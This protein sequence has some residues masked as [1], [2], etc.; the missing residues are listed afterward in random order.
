LLLVREM[1]TNT[2]ICFPNVF[3]PHPNLADEVNGN[4]VQS[5]IEGGVYLDSLSE[6]TALE[7]ETRNHVYRIVYCSRDTELISGHP[8]FCPAPVRVR[9][10]GSTWGGS[11]LKLRYIG[12]SMHLEFHHPDFGVIVTSCIVDVRTARQVTP[13]LSKDFLAT[14]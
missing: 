6:G 1:E 13:V 4:I 12:R 14:N 10:V 11:M 7:V 9:V 5:E 2:A 8:K 3:T